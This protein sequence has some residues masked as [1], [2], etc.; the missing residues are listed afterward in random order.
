MLRRDL[1]SLLF[2]F[3]FC[4]IGFSLFM[5][6]LLPYEI[7]RTFL[8][9][10]SPDGN[11]SL[12]RADNAVV[13][14]FLVGVLSVIMLVSAYLTGKR[15][16]KKV[17]ILVKHLGQDLQMLF[18]FSKTSKA[19]KGFLA[20]LFLVVVLG[21]ICRLAS[22]ENPMLHDEAYSVTTFTD[23][24]FHALT[25]YSL[26]NNHIFHTIL[27]SLS[28][29]VFGM[30]PWAVRLPA[31]LAGVLIIPGVY[32][33]AKHIYGPWTGLL[34]GVLVA[35]S[36]SLISYSTNARGYTLVAL[37]TLVILTL[38]HY[39]RRE[40][41]LFAWI[42]ISC[43][44]ALGLY[45]VPVMLFP[46][47]ILFVWLF[48][49]NL[50]TDPAPY[51]SKWK[52]LRYWLIAGLLT[53]ILTVMLYTPTLIYTSPQMIFANGFVA[54]LPWSD[55]PD[56]WHARLI[57]T[58]SEWTDGVPLPVTV[59][60]C[61][62]WVLSLIFHRKLSPVRIPLQLASF[63]GIAT[64]LIVQRSNAWARVWVFLLPLMLIW[65]SAGII[66][67]LQK[68]HLKFPYGI[69]LASI[70]T[71]LVLFVGVWSTIQQIPK[72]PGLLAQRGDV[73][74]AILFLKKNINDTDLIVVDWPDDSP[75]WFYALEHGI[76]NNHF[77]KRISYTRAWILI[78][79]PDGQTYDSV[80]ANR[81]PDIP[82][83]D[84]PSM[85]LI[86]TI[87]THQIYVCPIQ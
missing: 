80:L 78:N 35:F 45:T 48:S 68:V 36:H 19:E 17:L 27:V 37:F 16:W 14:R 41:N 9:V 79:P 3:L 10:S 87:G 76:N 73:E 49:E 39:V 66:G 64:L 54:P 25:D 77:D 62:G 33:L 52:F 42:L 74:N 13:F 44:S 82:A 1:F 55:I 30:T 75:A 20:A 71:G 61:A 34:A 57:D 38:G 2:T 60:L 67:L 51:S 8:S 23:T 85:K 5:I 59:I 58:W 7:M 84:L 86:Q 70:V 24:I 47:G 22:I 18:L 40:E 32:F 65:A 69:S 50:A 43:F 81:G 15:K 56:T 53:A 6:A 63:W 11:L 26:P 4:L 46:F 72:L 12:L 31:F 21:V 83:L 29:K 28:I